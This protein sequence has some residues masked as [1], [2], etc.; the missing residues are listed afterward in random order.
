M[1]FSGQQEGCHYD[2]L[3]P[4]EKREFMFFVVVIVVVFFC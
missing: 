1:S 3:P 2:I 4:I